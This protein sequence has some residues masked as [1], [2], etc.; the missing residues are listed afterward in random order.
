MREISSFAGE[1]NVSFVVK[2]GERASALEE[3]EGFVWKLSDACYHH[4]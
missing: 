4:V 3:T 2:V 1:T